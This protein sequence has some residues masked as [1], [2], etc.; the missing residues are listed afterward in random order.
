MRGGIFFCGV[1]GE[2]WGV[3]GRVFGG[4]WGVV[5]VGRSCEGGGGVGWVRKSRLRR[6]VGV[7]GWFFFFLSRGF[8]MFFAVGGF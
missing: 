1:G 2:G 4:V 8:L 3:L 7:D 6:T 5:S